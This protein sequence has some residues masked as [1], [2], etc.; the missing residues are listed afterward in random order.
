METESVLSDPTTFENG[1]GD[2]E[3][4]ASLATAAAVMAYGLS[5]RSA[6]GFALAAAATPL[7][8]RG[9][10]GEW[11]NVFSLNGRANGDTRS[12][13]SGN[14][15]VNVRESIRLEQPLGDVFALWSRLENLPRFMSHLESV[16]NL[17]NGRSHW[18]AKGP[19]GSTIEWDAEIINEIENKVIAWRSLP[20][21]D[22]AT[23]GSVNFSTAREG[24]ASQVSVN[25]QYA[26]P[27]GHAGAL[28]ASLFGKEPSQTIREDLR[29]A[30]QLLEAG[31]I[32]RATAA[33][34]E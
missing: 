13:L 14:R 31:E 15:G 27:A 23:A 19:A 20:G 26:P 8:Y 9:L 33:Q 34:Q 21:S 6:Y 2:L 12:A 16:T 11:P 3:R 17:G 22:I 10:A 32:A 28:V 18:V 7:A 1:I 4:W 5:R 24:R 29:R 25:L 30:K